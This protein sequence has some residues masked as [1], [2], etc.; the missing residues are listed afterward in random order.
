MNILTVAFKATITYNYE[1]HISL[2][3]T[4][5]IPFKIKTIKNE[6]DNF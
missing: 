4:F 1:P 5:K 2:K 6:T 3:I